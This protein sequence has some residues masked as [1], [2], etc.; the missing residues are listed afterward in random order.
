[1]FV[2]ELKGLHQAKGFING[3]P[4]RQVIDGDLPQNAFVINDEKT[5]KRMEKNEEVCISR[6]N[7]IQ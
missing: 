5:S 4:H 1:M 2:G 3:T 7:T 6:Y